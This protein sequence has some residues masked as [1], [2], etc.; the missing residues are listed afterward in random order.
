M[1]TNRRDGRRGFAGCSGRMSE[2]V[3]WKNR[4]TDLWLWPMPGWF[5]TTCN[6]IGGTLVLD[7]IAIGAIAGLG[8]M[9]FGEFAE[10]HWLKW[11]GRILLAPPVLLLSLMFATAWQRKYLLT[12]S[13]PQILRVRIDA[14]WNDDQVQSINACQACPWTATN[15]CHQ[16]EP[17]GTNHILQAANDGFHCP[18]CL[19]NGRTDVVR[20][21]CDTSQADWSW[22]VKPKSPS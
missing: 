16:R 9:V 8:C 2:G 7:V 5:I 11:L 19:S 4:H 10:V 12:N 14:P 3:M 1:R 15:V 18:V 13:Q 20:T 6:R 22:N 21:I 17:N